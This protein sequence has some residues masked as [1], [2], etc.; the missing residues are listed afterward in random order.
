VTKIAVTKKLWKQDK[1]Q[2]EAVGGW[3]IAGKPTYLMQWRFVLQFGTRM[4]RVQW[5]IR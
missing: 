5:K 4:I 1:E 2:G 3:T